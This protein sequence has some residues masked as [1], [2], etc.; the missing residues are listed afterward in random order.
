MYDMG[1]FKCQISSYERVKLLRHSKKL[2]CSSTVT[3]KNSVILLRVRSQIDV[4]IPAVLTG[5]HS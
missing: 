2:F 1:L 5:K 4:A 3:N